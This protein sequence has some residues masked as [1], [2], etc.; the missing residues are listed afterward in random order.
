MWHDCG[1]EQPEQAGE[2]YV[3]RRGLRG[4]NGA[5][6]YND[7]CVWQP[8]HWLNSRGTVIQTVEWWR[9]EKE[10]GS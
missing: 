3:V 8:P 7:W 2:Y 1:K 4:R 10:A 9:E 5:D 6:H